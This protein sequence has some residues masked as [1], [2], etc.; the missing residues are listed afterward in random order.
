MENTHFIAKFVFCHF[1]YKC[2]H[3]TRIHIYELMIS[4]SS[5]AFG[6][7]HIYVSVCV[8]FSNNF[9]IA[10]SPIQSIYRFVAFA[11][12]SSR[13]R[14]WSVCCV[15]HSGC[16]TTI[17]QFATF[18][19]SYCYVSWFHFCFYIMCFFSLHVFVCVCVCIFSPS[20]QT[21]CLAA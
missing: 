8:C 9:K 7:I 12:C 11:K 20:A 1:T 4:F 16:D 19:I 10:L 6:N 21:N 2:N 15:W 18:T 13:I 14:I 5:Y 17:S 3:H